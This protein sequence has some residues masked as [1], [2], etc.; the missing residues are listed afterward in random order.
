VAFSPDGAFL[1][2]AE[3]PKKEKGKEPPAGVFGRVRLWETAGWTERA[4][5][6]RNT[7]D[8]RAT[9]FSPDGKLLVYINH[10]EVMVY[11]VSVVKPQQRAELLPKSGVVTTSQAL[12]PDGRLLATGGADALIRVWDMDRVLAQ[13]PK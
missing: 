9:L 5:G 13:Q 2:A 6:K 8:V 4:V 10:K 12:S 1:A 11:D 3:K 7:G